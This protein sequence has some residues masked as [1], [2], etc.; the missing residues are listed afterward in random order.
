MGEYGNPDLNTFVL[1]EQP[2]NEPEPVSFSISPY[3]LL[4]KGETRAKIIVRL[5]LEEIVSWENLSSCKYVNRMSSEQIR[6]DWLGYLSTNEIAA[7]CLISDRHAL[8]ML[9]ILKHSEV[10][11]DKVLVFRNAKVSR[12][13][14]YPFSTRVHMWK[15]HNPLPDPVYYLARLRFNWDSPSELYKRFL[16]RVK[17]KRPF[18]VTKK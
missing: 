17:N 14:T 13:G 15:I 8:N 18:V 16:E 10:V 11:K 2:L 5:K 9:N 3:E 7:S 6:L 12:K 1:E 4:G